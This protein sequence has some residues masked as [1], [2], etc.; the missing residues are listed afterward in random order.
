M[1]VLLRTHSFVSCISVR[2]Y[3]QKGA[4]YKTSNACLKT[5]GLDKV[6]FLTVHGVNT[7]AHVQATLENSAD[8]VL[9]MKKEGKAEL[10]GVAVHCHTQDIITL[11][12]T[13]KFEVNSNSIFN[14]NNNIT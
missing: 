3:A 6:T 13:K 7:K 2:P 9:Q 14:L 4:L 5:L 8:E 11:I 10:V 1:L 12:E